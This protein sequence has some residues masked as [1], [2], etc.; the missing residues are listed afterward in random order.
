MKGIHKKINPPFFVSMT[1]AAKFV[2]PIPI[3]LAYLV[4]LDV[5]VVPSKFDQFLFGE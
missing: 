2:Q 1:T 5:D 3:C 4:S